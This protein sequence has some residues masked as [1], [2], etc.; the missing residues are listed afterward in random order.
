MAVFFARVARVKPLSTRGWLGLIAAE[1]LARTRVSCL[2]GWPAH[3]PWDLGGWAG[4][5]LGY[6][7]GQTPAVGLIRGAGWAEDRDQVSV[8][9]ASSSCELGLRDQKSAGGCA[10][11]TGQ[12]APGPDR[13]RRSSGEEAGSYEA[14]IYSTPTS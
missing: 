9:V 12:N 6:V 2:V 5:I 10:D 13:A 8:T 14:R 7:T 3:P 11:V 4:W 1:S